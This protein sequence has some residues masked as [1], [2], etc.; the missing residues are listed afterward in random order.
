MS[1]EE[2]QIFTEARLRALKLTR[3]FLNR[4]LS[5]EYDAALRA[6]LELKQ[7]ELAQGILTLGGRIDPGVMRGQQT[8]EVGEMLASIKGG[9]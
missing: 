5:Q 6:K 4:D 8:D 1:A 3:D 7:I 9:S 2:A